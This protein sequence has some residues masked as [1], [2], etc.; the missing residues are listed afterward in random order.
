MKSKGNAERFRPE[1]T[2]AG[3]SP[4]HAV[5]AM[6]ERG[7]VVEVDIA[8]EFPLTVRID[9]QEVV[10]LMTLGTHPEALALGYLRN[11][12]IVDEI[13]QV[14]SVA[15]DWD[16]E[17]V[18]IETFQGRAG[19]LL[20]AQA[21]RRI[22]TSGCGQGT[23]FSCTIDVLYEINVRPVALRQST[24]YAL[25][26]AVANHNVTYRKAGAVH[27]CALCN[28]D[29]VEIFIEDVGRHNAAD[30]VAGKMWLAG[31]SGGGRILYTTGRLTSEIVMK[32]AQ[33][34]IP[35]LLS[36]SGITH[37]GLELA[38]DLGI[39]MIA[40]AKGRKFLVYSGR[41]NIILDVPPA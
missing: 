25:L 27:A 11:Q 28:G 4:T 32:T 34:E 38:Q 6:N 17:T 36:R 35:V 13:E 24:I 16:A 40:R 2:V 12:R 14:R 1:M 5:P 21:S 8:G 23:M 18:D 26:K 10:T 22:V 3:L 9:R 37:M 29:R 31:L 41:K 7:K 19:G 33:L 20:Q 39:T 15:V 30:T